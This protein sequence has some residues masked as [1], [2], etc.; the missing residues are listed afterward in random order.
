MVPASSSSS[1]F[2]EL[3][4]HP[5]YIPCSCP[6]EMNIPLVSFVFLSCSFG[7]TEEYS[8]LLLGAI[9]CMPWL[10]CNRNGSSLFLPT[11]SGAETEGAVSEGN[12]TMITRKPHPSTLSDEDEIRKCSSTRNTECQCKP[13]TFKDGNNPEF[14]R[15]CSE[16]VMGPWNSYKLR[17]P[18]KTQV[19]LY[20]FL[21][22]RL[23]GEPTLGGVRIPTL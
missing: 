16:Y 10:W 3:E 1:C 15:K 9:V 13:G 4:E 2:Q 22:L 17:E 23:H 21:S 19:S 5:L 18:Q 20:P 12:V 7:L 14:C 8:K 11:F 6:H